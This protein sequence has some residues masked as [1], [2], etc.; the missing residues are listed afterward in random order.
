MQLLLYACSSLNT[1]ASLGV[2]LWKDFL[3]QLRHVKKLSAKLS[4]WS[5]LK[6]FF[7]VLDLCDTLHAY[8]AF[9]LLP[10]FTIVERRKSSLDHL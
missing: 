1:K 10:H 9:C 7:L 6:H 8:H 2:S 4:D 3:P 5:R